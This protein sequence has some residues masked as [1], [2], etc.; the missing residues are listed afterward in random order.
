MGQV[1]QLPS[2]RYRAIARIGGKRVTIGTYDYAYEAELEWQQAEQK[3]RAILNP[4]PAEPPH[5]GLT[6]HQHGAEWLRRRRGAL[7]K[8]TALNYATY[9]AF[10]G[11]DPLGPLP[12]AAIVK[13]DVEAAV[14]RWVSAGAGPATVAGRYRTLRMILRD[15]RGNG[16]TDRDA[17][18]GVK[19]PTVPER[20]DS[21]LAPDHVEALLVSAA[22]LS[23]AWVV[24]ILAGVEA[25]LRWGEAAALAPANITEDRIH[26]RQVIERDGT[27][28]PYPKGRRHRTIRM[29]ARLR[30]ALRPLAAQI[31]LAGGPD[32]L[33]FTSLE[34]GPLDYFN[35]RQRVWRPIRGN[36]VGMRKSGVCF[37]DLRHTYGSRLAAAGVPD[38]EIMRLMGHADA[39]TTARY[40]HAAG[41]DTTAA[42]VAHA[43]DGAPSPLS[44]IRDAR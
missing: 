27:V 31:E 24:F 5:G 17:T 13:A 4:E 38:D 35:Y 42:W 37:H 32:A 14:T 3:A 12:V 34:G 41:Y 36:A 9:V 15:G 29:S 8:A 16:L 33:I 2:G 1:D 20:A 23:P 7:T 11:R 44:A 22:K 6:L 43:L 30:A 19:L 10:L 21:F 39:A 26:V 40:K 25:G 28:R 18:A